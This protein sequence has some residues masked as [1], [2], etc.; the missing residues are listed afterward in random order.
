MNFNFKV[1]RIRYS[2]TQGEAGVYCNNKF[3]VQYGD[4]ID[5]NENGQWE[6]TI[7]DESFISGAMQQYTKE[8]LKTAL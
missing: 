6:S 1:K 5:I 3:I 4:N 7:K 8:I 2:V